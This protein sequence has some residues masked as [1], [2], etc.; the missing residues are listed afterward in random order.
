MKRRWIVSSIATLAVLLVLGRIVAGWHV[1]ARWYGALDAGAVW[2]AKAVNMLLLRGGTF[3]AG[4]LFVLANLYAVRHSVRRLVLPRRM[5]NLDFGE[6]VPSRYLLI[7][8]L[9]LSVLIGALLALPHDDWLSVDLIRHGIAFGETDPYFQRD[10]AFWVYWLPLESSLHVWALVALLTVSMLVVLLYALTPSLRWE[11]G[12]LHVS[13]YVRRHIFTLG[14][15][16]LLL[17]AWSYRLD[18]YGLLNGGR[19]PLGGFSAVDH[20][21]VLPASLILSVVAVAAAV[22]VLW[23]GW[24]GQIRLAFVTITCVLLLALA[25]RQIVPPVAERFVTPQDPE[26]RELPYQ[27]TRH[28]YTRR[29]YDVDRLVRDDEPPAA[30]SVDYAARGASL[31]DGAALSRALARM[32]PASSLNG[33]LGWD[34]QDGRLVALAIE[35][36]SGPDA[37]NA[38]PTWRVSRVAADVADERGAPQERLDPDLVTPILTDVLVHHE[39]TDYL[40]IADSAGRIAAPDLGSLLSRVSHAWHL[41]NPRLLGDDLSG[42]A[43]RVVWR[44]DVRERVRA[45]YPFFDQAAQISPVV[46]RDSLFWAVHLYATSSWYPLS[47]RQRLGARDVHYLRH[48][49]VAIV[50]AHTG[51]TVAIADPEPDPL[52]SSWMRRF[53]SLFVAPSA[54]DRGL[55]Q[56]VPPAIEGTLIA[57][58]AFAQVGVRGEAA[59]TS[60]LPRHTGGDTLFTS[61][62]TPPFVDG[63]SGLLSVAVPIL[64]H[65]DRLRGAVTSDGGAEYRPRWRPLT[66]AGP[67]WSSVVERLQRPTDSMRSVIRDT[68]LLQGPVRVVPAVGGLIALETHYTTRPDGTPQALYVSV[69]HRDTVLAGVSIASAIGLPAPADSQAPITPEGFRSRVEALYGAMRDALRRSDWA[70]FGAAYEALGRLLSARQ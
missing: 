69:L 49:A 70:A 17:L 20:R 6:E 43:V 14:A 25:L 8:V 66:S 62:T 7:A 27:V 58:A 56:G 59:P 60:H 30:Q 26:Q 31:W 22:L 35:Q 57:A 34:A 9:A 50:N 42:P 2:R 68:R 13:G 38:R 48:A 32:H 47:E 67:T 11:A 65:A 12:Q 24:T 19:G 1:D 5:G 61:A 21:V 10:L 16:L 53:P 3:L 29:A 44:R 39:A 4:T 28:G 51:R 54:F 55:M 18:A 46:W 36:P 41:Q 23:S 15:V 63:S 40:V 52:T 37:A 45:V 64:D 33:S